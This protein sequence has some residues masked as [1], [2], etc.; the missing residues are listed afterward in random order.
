MRQAA[1][2]AYVVRRDPA[3]EPLPG[4][5]QFPPVEF[6]VHAPAPLQEYD[7]T[8]RSGAPG[9]YL[10]PAWRRDSPSRQSMDHSTEYDARRKPAAKGR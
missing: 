8:E 7:P 4:M 3:E 1:D 10:V 2:L 6:V 5:R 9:V